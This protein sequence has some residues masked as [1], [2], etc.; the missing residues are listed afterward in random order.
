MRPAVP[1]Q[2]FQVISFADVPQ[3]ELRYL[4]CSQQLSP[5]VMQRV[6]RAIRKVLGHGESAGVHTN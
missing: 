2:H 6:N 3:G 4:M 5:A 1:L